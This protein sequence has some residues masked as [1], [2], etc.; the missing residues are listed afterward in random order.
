MS[1]LSCTARYAIAS[2][3]E[4]FILHNSDKTYLF[5]KLYHARM[6]HANWII[7]SKITYEIIE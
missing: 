4:E 3:D 2:F 7:D 1:Q 5:Y 6:Y